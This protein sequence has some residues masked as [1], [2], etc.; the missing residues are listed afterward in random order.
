[1]ALLGSGCATI[2]ATPIVTCGV[3]T[4]DE[5]EYDVYFE[6]NDLK[7]NAVWGSAAFTIEEF[8]AINLPWRWHKNQ[9]REGMVDGGFFSRS[10]DCAEDGA[11]TEQEMYDQPWQHIVNLVSLG[12]A[13]DDEGLLS[14]NRVYKHHEILF[15]AG[16]TL[17]VLS[18]PAG[19]DFVLVSRDAQRTSEVPTLPTGWTLSLHPLTQD[20]WVSLSGTVD[21]IRA[22]NEDS[23]QGPLPADLSLEDLTQAE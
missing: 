17:T 11:F 4:V 9:P 22:D 10:P 19:E 20:L 3:P 14:L 12:E 7:N 18:S 5:G 1:L 21:N 16:R 15:S 8:E 2:D 13:L 6:V 23:F